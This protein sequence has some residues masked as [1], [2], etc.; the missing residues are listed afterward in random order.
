MDV[1]GGEA[2]Q[3]EAGSQLPCVF[4][5]CS[6][7]YKHIHIDLSFELLSNSLKGV[8]AVITTAERSGNWLE[9]TEVLTGKVG[10]LPQSFGVVPSL[11]YGYRGQQLWCWVK[12]HI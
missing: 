4:T 3:E 9:V 10:I 11:F 5:P 7:L 8:N 1:A 2:G 12:T 6:A